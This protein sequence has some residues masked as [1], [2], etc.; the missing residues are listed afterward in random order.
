MQFSIKVIVLKS[1]YSCKY[2]YGGGFGS[3]KLRIYFLNNSNHDARFETTS[4]PLFGCT[5]WLDS[6]FEGLFLTT[7]TSMKLYPMIQ[8][9]N[10]T[11]R[12]DITHEWRCS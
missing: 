6:N 5:L 2:N 7:A 8:V 12:R 11:G 10:G 4:H 1:F 9:P 3:L